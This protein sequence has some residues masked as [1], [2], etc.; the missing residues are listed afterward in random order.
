MMKEMMSLF[1]FSFFS[2]KL[3]RQRKS[4]N[5]VSRSSTCILRFKLFP[6]CTWSFAELLNNYHG[7]L[8]VLKLVTSCVNFI[9]IFRILTFLSQF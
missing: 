3:V 4:V 8:N 1:F 5:A 9:R 7:I 6:R 2:V